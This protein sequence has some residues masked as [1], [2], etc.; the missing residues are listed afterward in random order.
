[1]PYMILTVPPAAMA[2][3][4]LDAMATQLFGM[5]KPTAMMRKGPMSRRTAWVSSWM[6]SNCPGVLSSED[7]A[8]GARGHGLLQLPHTT[9][10]HWADQQDRSQ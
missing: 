7:P 9:K 10:G 3:E 2:M 6:I 4:R 1:M 8:N 5:L